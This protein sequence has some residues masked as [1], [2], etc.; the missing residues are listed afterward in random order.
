MGQGSVAASSWGLTHPHD[1]DAQGLIVSAFTDLE[2]GM[3]LLLALPLRAGGAWLGDLCKIAPVTNAVKPPKGE[4]SRRPSVALA[5]TSTGLRAMGLDDDCLATFSA[6][7][8]EGMRQIDRQR[9]LGD[10]A[11]ASTV[12]AGGPLWSGNAFDPDALV[13]AAVAKPTAITVHAALLL[14]QHDRKSLCELKDDVEESL[15]RFNVKVVRRIEMKLRD[16]KGEPREHFGFVD[17]ISQPIPYGAAIITGGTQKPDPFHTV[18]AGDILMGH[19]DADAEVPPGP[20]VSDTTPG[21]HILP[22]GHAPHGSKDLG[23]D[24]SYLVIRELRQDV[25]AFWQTMRQAADALDDPKCDDKWVAA[26]VV[27][28]TLDTDPA[29]LG[30]PMGSHIRRANPRDGLAPTSGDG[31]VFLHASNNHRI[32]RRG[33][34]FGPSYREGEQPTERGLLFIALNTDIARQ[35]ESIQQTWVLNHNFATLHDETDPLIGGAGKF[36]VPRSPLRARVDVNTFVRLAGGDY[37]FLPSLPAI[38]FLKQLP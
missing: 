37:F 9:R 20:I 36:T 21:A 14:Y 29:G 1:T 27:G 31:G 32:L 25:G 34:K 19:Q 12:V 3:A 15:R 33:R 24:G 26:R 17:G 2:A 5:F 35:F 28:R 22:R 11:G 4:G 13:G 8:V 6:P 23:L 18:A 7:F 10:E 16:D 30:C 38:C